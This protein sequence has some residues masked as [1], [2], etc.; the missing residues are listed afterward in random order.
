MVD[1]R[2]SDAEVAFRLEAGSEVSKVSPAKVDS[3]SS[4]A[5]FESRLEAGPKV[6]A[7]QGPG[8]KEIPRSKLR[9]FRAPQARLRTR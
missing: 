9:G 5:E 1:S 7:T 4:D 6:R 2:S 8:R 3:R